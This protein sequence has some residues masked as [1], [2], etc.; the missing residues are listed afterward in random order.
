MEISTRTVKDILT[1]FIPEVAEK[2]LAN[3]EKQNNNAI[4]S[5][6]PKFIQF[7]A[8]ESLQVAALKCA[9]TFDKSDEGF[10]Y[11]NNICINP[12]EYLKNQNNES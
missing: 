8:K 11:W 12:N 7:F 3:A 9:F 6:V 4:H 5:S 10:K 2:A 1:D